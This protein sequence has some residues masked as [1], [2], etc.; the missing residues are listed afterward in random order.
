[1]RILLSAAAML[2]LGGCMSS[3]D[4]NQ[5]V[6]FGS[7]E[8]YQNQ[9]AYIARAGVAGPGAPMTAGANNARIS[10]EQSFEAVS[11]RETIS[12]DRSR[13]EANR[14]QYQ[15]VQATPVPAR[16]GPSK[17]NIAEFALSTSHPIGQQM[18]RRS[19][20]R[21]NNNERA[22]AKYASD[23]LA[24]EA[25]LSAGGPE[26][27]RHGLDPDGDGYA[28]RWDPAAFRLARG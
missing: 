5:G 25:F 18:Y 28:C 26:R 27:D 15:T 23:S 19:A 14:A 13:I 9:Q 11:A 24:Q 10:D 20:L 7:Y 6:G 17:A 1:M 4:N 8:L 3:E 12:S 22:C 21:G 2:A 16:S